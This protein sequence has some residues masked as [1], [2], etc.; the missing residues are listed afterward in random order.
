MVVH[1]LYSLVG[2]KTVERLYVLSL[3]THIVVIGGELPIISAT[4]VFLSM[5]T[6]GLFFY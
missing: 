4:S 1:E 2:L 3:S 6:K 5:K